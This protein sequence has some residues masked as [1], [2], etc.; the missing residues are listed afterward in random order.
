MTALR[1]FHLAIP[2][3]DLERARVFYGDVLGCDVGRRSETWMDFD[4]FGHQVSVHLKPAA[5]QAAQ[6]NPVDAHAVPVRHFGVI[7]S[8]EDWHRL[9]ERLRAL[10]TEF[11]IEPGMRFSGEVGEQATLFVCDPSGN[12]LEFKAFSQPN[13]IFAC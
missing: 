4:F 13:Q 3:S 7:L 9:V 1:P 8:M 6:T 5:V 11:L 2:V 12:A 10:R